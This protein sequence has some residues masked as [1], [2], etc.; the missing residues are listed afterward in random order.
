MDEDEVMQALQSCG[1][2]DASILENEAF[3][4]PETCPYKY[5]IWIGSVNQSLCIEDA[6]AECLLMSVST[7][8]PIKCSELMA[9]WRNCKIDGFVRDNP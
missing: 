3:N 2:G 7:R 4:H 5:R 6:M 8:T 9:L 1:E